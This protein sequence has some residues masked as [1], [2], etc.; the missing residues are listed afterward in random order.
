MLLTTAP[1]SMAAAHRT[2]CSTALRNHIVLVMLAIQ[3]Q[4]TLAPP[5]I[6]AR[7]ATAG[8]HKPACLTAQLSRTARAMPDIP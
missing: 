7:A 4:D 1:P 3:L 5:S 6:T 8:V 2:A